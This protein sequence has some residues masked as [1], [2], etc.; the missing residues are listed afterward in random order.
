MNSQGK[1]IG[2]VDIATLN[3]SLTPEISPSAT[4]EHAVYI[5]QYKSV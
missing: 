1:A 2:G 4:I 3:D 5:V